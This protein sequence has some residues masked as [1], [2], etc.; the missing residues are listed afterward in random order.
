[1]F[2]Y[3]SLFALLLLSIHSLLLLHDC[4]P[5][6]HALASAQEQNTPVAVQGHSHHPHPHHGHSHAHSQ[7]EAPSEESPAQDAPAH[8]QLHHHDLFYSTVSADIATAEFS[9]LA[10][11]DIFTYAPCY[12]ERLQPP[13][14]GL[15]SNHSPPPLRASC[16]LRAPPALV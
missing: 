11:G 3:R 15:V 9:P 13:A 2:I 6:V 14:E 1:M 16:A 4:V 12:R 10:L 7:P 8:T 5:H